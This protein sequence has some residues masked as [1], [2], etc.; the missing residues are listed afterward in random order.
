MEIS[1]LAT[2]PLGHVTVQTRAKADL[3][4]RLLAS[5]EIR[6]RCAS[7]K[8]EWAVTA[9]VHREL[10]HRI[11]MDDWA[12]NFLRVTAAHTDGVTVQQS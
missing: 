11:Q 1:F 7:C 10:Q 3:M 6:L 5:F 8:V 12:E 9:E 4:Q 2:C